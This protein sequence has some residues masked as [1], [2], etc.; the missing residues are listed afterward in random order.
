MIRECNEGDFEAIRAVINDAALAYKGVIPSFLYREPWA[1]SE[2]LKNELSKG[3]RFI[4]HDEQGELQGV[5]GVQ[6]FPDVTLI[7]H[8]YVRTASQRTGIGSALLRFHM[9]HAHHRILVGCLKAMTWAIAFYEKHGFTLVSDAERDEL[10][11]RYWD[12]SPEHVANS[13]VLVKD[14]RRA[15]GV[16]GRTGMLGLVQPN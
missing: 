14:E 8:S 12:L 7:R 9:T 4:C 3:V 6:E 5:M 2:Y 13:V 1:S 16:A 10:R 15:G 11:A